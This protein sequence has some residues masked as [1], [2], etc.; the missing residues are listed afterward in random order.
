MQAPRS[1]ARWV[2]AALGAFAL[3]MGVFGLI[4]PDEQAR[5]MGFAPV[6]ARSPGDYTSTLLAITSLATI[7]TAALYLVGAGR[8][9]RGFFRWAVAARSFMGLGLV[10]LA[11]SGRA[12]S[13]FIGAAI[14]EWVG[15][16]AI[17]AASWWDRRAAVK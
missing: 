5:M 14:W 4:R 16:A 10:V 6:V 11:M 13:A 7:N 9:W 12:P 15:A 3:V 8:E 1:I 2:V 17:G